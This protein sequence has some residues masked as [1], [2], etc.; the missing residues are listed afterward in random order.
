MNKFFSY[1]LMMLSVLVMFTSCQRNEKVSPVRKN[2]E[3]AVFGS[4]HLEQDDEYIVSATVSGVIKFLPVKEGDE[5]KPNDLIATIRS[6]VQHSQLEDARVT[7]HDALRN[8][9]TDSPQLK[10]IEAQI[11]QAQHQ[12]DLDKVNYLR[13]KD[14]RAKNSVSQLDF[15]KAELQYNNSRENMELLQKRYREIRNSLELTVDRSRIQISAQQA[16]LNDYAISSASA[17]CVID[18]YKKKGEV[19]RPGDALAKIG[20]GSYIIKLY[21]SEDDISKVKVGQ[22]VAVHLNTYPNDIF[23]AKVTRILPGF[24][25]EEQSYVIEASFD[26]L[27]PTIFSDTQLQANIETGK[28]NGVLVIPSAYLVK[29]RYVILKDGT[30]KE[31]RTGSRSSDWVEIVSGVTEKDILIKSR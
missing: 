19:V 12:L 27:P 22:K 7:Y 13:Y 15:D 30:Q 20:S 1:L 25:E 10:Q 14:L 16:L 3:D 11:A 2:I 6:D 31:V 26:L 8:A 9:A 24:N 17:G 28:R 4:G 5:V 18:V 23:P 29:G 21:I